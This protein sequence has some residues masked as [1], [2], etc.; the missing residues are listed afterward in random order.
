[1]TWEGRLKQAAYI[2]PSGNR[3]TFD[4]EDV[5]MNV[6]K[7]TSAFEFPEVNGTYIQDNGH[8]GRRFPLNIF[9]WGSDYDLES[10]AFLDA[11]LE[12]G[13][14]QLDHPIYGLRD[15]VPFGT[16]ERIDNL[17]TAANQAIFQVLFWETTGIIYPTNQGDPTTGA[18]GAIKD[19][20]EGASGQFGD[21]LDV[22]SAIEEVTFIDAF[23]QVLKTTKNA[24]QVVADTQDNVR[25][26]FN[27]INNAINESIE[28]LVDTPIT[29]AFQTLE[30]IQAPGRAL[31]SITD[32]LEGYGNLVESL[33]SGNG[34][35]VQSGNDSRVNNKFHTADLYAQ[36]YV[37]GALISSVNNQFKTRT[38]AINSAD[39]LFNMFDQVTEWREENFTSLEIIDT[40]EAY[41][42]LQE[43]VAITAGFLVQIS[44]TL[45]Q[46]RRFTTDRSHTMVDL[47]GQLYGEIDEQ[48]D[49]FIDSNNLTGS[50]I[51]EI[52]KGREIVYYV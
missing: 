7:R 12:S 41:Q 4:Y 18:L 19:F 36:G 48:L 25:R 10:N 16:I 34:V 32:R 50:E 23:Q 30:L 1:M 27:A 14:G 51:L 43:A 47:V 8:S 31:T 5:S 29:L 49:F 3:I 45:L 21:L 22:D 17:K 39:L 28:I 13:V 35:A 38:E 2:T 46:E 44:F 9:F 52:P 37:S 24:L 26:Q 20:S 40:G 42:G 33:I 11:L 15:V 6:D